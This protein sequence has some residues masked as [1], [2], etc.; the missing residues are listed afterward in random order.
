MATDTKYEAWLQD[1]LEEA[2]DAAQQREIRELLESGDQHRMALYFSEAENDGPPTGIP[3]PKIEFVD[4][5]TLEAAKFNPMGRVE[6]SKVKALME[7]IKQHGIL[8]PLLVSGN[9]IV[10]GHRRWT[11]ALLLKMS[12]VPIIRQDGKA[13]ADLYETVNSTARKL[14]TMD[15]LEVW[16]KGGKISDKTLRSINWL[17]DRCGAEMLETLLDK[18]ISPTGVRNSTIMVANYCQHS[19]DKR[20]EMTVIRWLVKHKTQF[21]VRVAINEMI[22][23]EL[24]EKAIVDDK[25]LKREWGI[26]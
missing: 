5:D 24:M 11:C 25:P 19:E 22:P 14:T 17:K 7:S 16:M 1:L 8:Q 4:P 2:T 26:R 23:A 6:E 3:T 12:T 9:T 20:F 21:A 18:R 13:L 15:E 10:D